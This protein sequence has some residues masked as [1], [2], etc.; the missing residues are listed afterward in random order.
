MKVADAAL[1]KVFAE[2]AYSDAQLRV[3]PVTMVHE[4]DPGKGTPRS[5]ERGDG[6]C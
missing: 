2:D 3:E 4:D 1:V 6:S 5:Q